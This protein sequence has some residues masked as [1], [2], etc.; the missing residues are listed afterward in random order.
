M[1]IPAKGLENHAENLATQNLDRAPSAGQKSSAADDRGS[2]PRLGQTEQSIPQFSA[3]LSEAAAREYIDQN[4]EPSDWLA[5]VVRNRETGETIQ[6]ITTADK[7]RSPEFQSWL[8]YKNA[9][10]SD[11]YLSL[12]TFQEKAP[13]RTK[14]DVKEIRHLYLDLDDDGPRKLAAIRSDDSVPEPS[15]VL[16]TS[17]G[18]LQVL[19]K[20]SNISQSE[21]ESL[22]RELAQHFGGDPA[23]T[24]STRVF[25]LTGFNNKKYEQNFPVTI[26]RKAESGVVYRS[27]DFKISNATERPP[28]LAPLTPSVRSQSER[29]DSQSERDWSYA[30]RQLKRG[31]K[32]EDI[33]SRISEYRSV[34]R[35][36]PQNPATLVSPRKP[37]PRYYAE[38]TV[39]R[40][41]AQLGRTEATNSKPEPQAESSSREIE[42]SR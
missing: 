8:R 27:S 28:T 3:S 40:A 4:F 13:G 6:R 2:L 23:A 11:I 39:A 5:V 35:Y 41:I 22:L 16:N 33:V 15:Y 20:V 37:N 32:P 21:A 26:H 31:E 1:T 19:W 34:D 25:R 30:L 29:G 24:D 7:I 17:P 10:G 42:P 9:Q 38:H 12:N 36:D 14:A 18:K